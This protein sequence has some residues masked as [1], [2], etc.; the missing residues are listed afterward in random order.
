MA[1]LLFTIYVLDYNDD[2]RDGQENVVGTLG[3]VSACHNN[4]KSNQWDSCNGDQEP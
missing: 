2:D 1:V 4:I 3:S